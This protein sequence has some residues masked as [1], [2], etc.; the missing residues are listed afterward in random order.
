M[1][2]QV[3]ILGAGM[4]GSAL[5]LWLRRLAADGLLGTIHPCRSATCADD[6]R[7]AFSLLSQDVLVV[8]E[9]VFQINAAFYSNSHSSSPMLEGVRLL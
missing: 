9:C 7:S 6:V 4:G 5:A 1:F 2:C 8:S 3:A